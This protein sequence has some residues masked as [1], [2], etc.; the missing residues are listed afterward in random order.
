LSLLDDADCFAPGALLGGGATFC[1]IT[2]GAE[3][4]LC[5]ALGAALGCVVG[6]HIADRNNARMSEVIRYE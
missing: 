5:G 6:A 1:A 4:L 2:V 3:V